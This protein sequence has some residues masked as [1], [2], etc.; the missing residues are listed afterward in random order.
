M[1]EKRNSER[2]LRSSK[3]ELLKSREAQRDMAGKISEKLKKWFI[4]Q[5]CGDIESKVPKMPRVNLP[6]LKSVRVGY[7]MTNNMLFDSGRGKKREKKE[8]HNEKA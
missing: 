1:K 2:S 8:K 4:K 5:L 6:D 7:K 3:H